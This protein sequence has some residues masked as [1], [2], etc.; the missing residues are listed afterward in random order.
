MISMFAFPLLVPRGSPLTPALSDALFRLMESGLLE[1]WNAERPLPPALM[2]IATRYLM[3]NAPLSLQQLR[4]A[5]I[6]YV[7][8]LAASLL[9]F[10]VELMLGWTK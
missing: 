3:R 10:A 7:L 1:K 5:F 6:V 4:A 8:C 9:A 2:R